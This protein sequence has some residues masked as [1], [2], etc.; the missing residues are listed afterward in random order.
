[1]IFDFWLWTCFGLNVLCIDAINVSASLLLNLT[2]SFF[3]LFCFSFVCSC[4]SVETYIYLLC[5]VVRAPFPAAR[6]QRKRKG[7]ESARFN[8]QPDV[9]C[10]RAKRF[11]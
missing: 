4:A 2:R 7:E 8:Y 11:G 5:A 1:M 9:I 10:S 6:I 3:F